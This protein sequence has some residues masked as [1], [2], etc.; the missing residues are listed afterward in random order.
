MLCEERMKTAHDIGMPIHGL[1]APAPDWAL[2]LDVDGT[3]AEIAPTP[4]AATLGPAAIVALIQAEAAL[5]G[6]LALVS[7]RAI[8]DLDRLTGPHRFAAAGQHGAEWRIDAGPTVTPEPPAGLAAAHAELQAFAARHP[9]V[10]VEDKGLS[11]ALHTRQAPEL[12]PEALALVD[13]VAAGLAGHHAF[14]G[15]A[16]AEIRADGANKGRAIERLMAAAPFRG[17]VPVFAGDD[18]TDEDGFR[19]V[20]SRG[21]ISIRVGPP[22]PPQA[23]AA[24]HLCADVPALGAWLAGLPAA[25]GRH[26]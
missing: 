8:A 19:F 11:L 14:H 16:V 1:P 20:N 24:R 17:R 6:D 3:L 12:G 13:R 22:E 26:G 2:F 10:L 18:R 5:G 7:G 4:G 25:L 23:S 9:G 15:K 21:G